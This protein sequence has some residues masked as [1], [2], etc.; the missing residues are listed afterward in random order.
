MEIGWRW[1]AKKYPHP[2]FSFSFISSSRF[3]A[4][5]K[6]RKQRPPLLDLDQV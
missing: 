5:A 2:L 6:L 4:A 3:I 1:G